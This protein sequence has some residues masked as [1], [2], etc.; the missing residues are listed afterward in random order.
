M[1]DVVVFVVDSCSMF[2]A[3]VIVLLRASLVEPKNRLRF[4]IV[5]LT[6]KMF[7]S[8]GINQL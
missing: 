1:F 2:D 7:G 5:G 4:V 6:K 8:V 3:G